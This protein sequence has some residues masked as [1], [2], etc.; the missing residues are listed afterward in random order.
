MA[1]NALLRLLSPLVLLGRL[2]ACWMRSDRTRKTVPH[3]QVGSCLVWAVITGTLS[4]AAATKSDI[5]KATSSTWTIGKN[6]PDC[7]CIYTISP[8]SWSGL[9]RTPIGV[10]FGGKCLRWPVFLHFGKGAVGSNVAYIT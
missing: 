3:S 4:E 9:E 10:T 1:M 7:V 6:G 5:A 8:Q 2:A